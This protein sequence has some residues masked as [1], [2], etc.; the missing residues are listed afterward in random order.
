MKKLTAA[1]IK[2]K[3]AL[4]ASLEAVGEEITQAIQLFNKQLVE[5]QDYLEARVG[6]YNELVQDANAFM[7]GVHDEQ[8]SFY[9]DRSEAWQEGDAGQNYQC[10][11]DEWSNEMDEVEDLELPDPIEEP[12][13][14]A[15]DALR[16]LAEQP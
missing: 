3:E 5:A 13:F 11:A 8:E 12:E 2:T 1:Q 14:I 10:W 6:R 7:A 16:D 9:A 15:A 4:A